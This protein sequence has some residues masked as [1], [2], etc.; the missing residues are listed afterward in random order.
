MAGM[1]DWYVETAPLV[2]S[3]AVT[4]GLSCNCEHGWVVADEDYPSG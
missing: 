2:D 1:D 4:D 3:D